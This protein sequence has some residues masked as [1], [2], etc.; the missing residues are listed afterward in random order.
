MFEKQNLSGKTKYSSEWCEA[1]ETDLVKNQEL[2]D[3]LSLT[4]LLGDKGSG[5]DW[6]KN[7]RKDHISHF[8]LR[9]AYCRTEELRRWFVTHET[10]LFKYRWSHYKKHAVEEIDSFM[11]ASGLNYEAISEEEKEAKRD[12]LRNSA[13]Y[14]YGQG[15]QFETETYYKVAWLE[16]MDLVRTR[17]VFLEK[18]FAYIPATEILSLIVG[19][20]RSKLSH[21]LVLTCRALPALEDDTRLVNMVQNLDKRWVMGHSISSTNRFILLSPGTLVKITLLTRQLDECIPMRLMV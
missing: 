20:F 8:I 13:A 11:S 17:R 1:I 4:K 10:D 3:F 6:E 19:V 15:W 21:N 14:G 5:Q 7:R 9:L 12:K 2:R 18:G 16:A